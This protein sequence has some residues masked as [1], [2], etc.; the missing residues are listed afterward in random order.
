MSS[1]AGLGSKNAPP[2]T[3]VT[4]TLSSSS[5][6]HQPRR[7]QREQKIAILKPPQMNASGDTAA[8]A[9]NATATTTAKAN[10]NQQQQQ[11]VASL[12]NVSSHGG[13]SALQ[14]ISTAKDDKEIDSAL[15]SALRDNKERM[16]L[17]RLE[18]NLID[19]MNDKN[20]ASMQVGGPFNTSIIKGANINMGYCGEDLTH[21]LDGGNAN[22]NANATIQPKQSGGVMNGYGS[23]VD[24]IR[25]GRQTSFQRLCLHKLADRFNIDRP[26]MNNRNGNG[27]TSSSTPHIRLLKVEESRI[28]TVKLIDLDMTNYETSLNIPQDRGNDESD[29]GNAVKHISELLSGAQIDNNGGGGGGGGSNHK[30]SKKKEK[31]KI[32]KRSPNSG[33]KN[34][35]K[36]SDADKKKRRGK[37]LSERE[38]AYAE[39]RARIFEDMNSNSGTD[40]GGDVESSTPPMRSTCSA[41][42]GSPKLLTPDSSEHQEQERN[43][44]EIVIERDDDDVNVP[45]AVKSGAESKV[46]WRNRQQEASDPDFRRAHHPIMVQQPMYHSATHYQPNAAMVNAPMDYGHGAAYHYQQQ[47]VL[48]DQMYPQVVG[49]Q[50]AYYDA[51]SW[52][53]QDNGGDD[54]AFNHSGTDAQFNAYNMQEIPYGEGN[55][56]GGAQTRPVYNED[57]FPALG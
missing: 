33:D 2:L 55:V 13:H 31:V 15:I 35:K 11:H 9:T 52:Q 21:T 16:A 19:F 18:Q 57:E 42:S 53:R 25:A 26:K 51:S 17:L 44:A 6:T 24:N 32:M 14:T 50:H 49:A 12:G 22:T 56:A 47:G 45:A 39:A 48:S 29:A 28:P 46:L 36:N 41:V 1:F 30:K 10:L 43:S 8:N 5:T 27:L 23:N 20:C 38:K 40:N 4:T 3:I 34:L 7:E 37:K 54:I